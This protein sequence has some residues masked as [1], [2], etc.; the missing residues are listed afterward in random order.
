MKLFRNA[1]RGKNREQELAQVGGMK[2]KGNR[3]G[4]EENHPSPL[5]SKGKNGCADG[6]RLSIG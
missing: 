2:E 5:S 6:C 4:K 3:S 1:E